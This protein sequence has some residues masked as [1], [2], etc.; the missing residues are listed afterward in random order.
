MQTFQLGGF[1]MHKMLVR[2]ALLFVLLSL[3]VGCAAPAVPV[4][5]D[6]S[7]NTV[8]LTN[9][10][11]QTKTVGMS[12]PS[13]VF[14]LLVVFVIVGV[15]AYYLKHQYSSGNFRERKYSN[16]LIVLASVVLLIVLLVPL[17]LMGGYTTIDSGEIGVVVRQGEA[18]RVLQP[19]PNMRVP[20]VDRVVIFPTRDWTYATMGDPT[21]GNEDYR[22]FPVT[23]VSQDGVNVAVVYTIQGRLD[24]E[25]ALEV[26][27][28]FKTLENAIAQGVKFSSRVIVRESLQSFVADD[29]ISKIDT[30][31]TDVLADLGP[32]MSDSGLILE[33]FGFRKP[34]L[35]IGGDY[36]GELNA[37][38]VAKKRAV[39]AQENVAVQVAEANRVAAEAEGQKRAAIARAEAEAERVKLEADAQAYQIT[40]QAAAEAGAISIVQEALAS[41]PD[42]L[43]YL[44]ITAWQAGGS[45]VPTTVVGVEGVV[46]WLNLGPQAPAQPAN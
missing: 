27:R 31:T 44:Q 43:R 16:G 23:M 12:L 30:V 21:R 13:G 26:Y 22:D 24:P 3:L 32:K 11:I 28:R 1:T 18:I 25:K 2:L 19:G 45:R 35:G 7:G 34:T 17:T 39:T 9:P 15:V 42:Y 14:L 37:A 6:A 8:V 46:P 38:Q 5:Q 33:L 20:Y 41:G 10:S 29:L 4:A 40:A 36:E